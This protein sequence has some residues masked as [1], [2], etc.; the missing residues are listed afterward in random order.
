VILLFIC[1][2][3]ILKLL[4]LRG[5]FLRKLMKKLQ[6][7]IIS[8]LACV[9]MGYSQEQAC[10]AVLQN[11]EGETVEQGS[12]IGQGAVSGE[13]SKFDNW[14]YNGWGMHAGV[15]ATMFFGDVPMSEA[16]NI[17]AMINIGLQKELTPYLYW[18]IT[19]AYGRLAGNKDEYSNGS[20]ANLE[21]KTK[22]ADI[23]TTLKLDLFGFNE[24]LRAKKFAPYIYAGYGIVTFRSI[25]SDSQSGDR[26]MAYGY[27]GSKTVAPTH[28][29][30]IPLGLGL[31]WKATQALSFTLDGSMTVVHSDKV[32]ACVSNYNDKFL[33]DM[34]STV[35]LG[36]VYKFGTRDCD[37]DGVVNRNDK[38][39]DTPY[40]VAVNEDGCP[41]DSDGDG[42]PDYQDKCPKEAGLAQFEGC[43]DSDGDGIPDPDDECPQEAGLAQFNGCPDSDGDGI[44]DKDD[45]CPQEPGLAEFNGCPDSDGDGVPDKDDKCPDAA[46][47]AKYDGCPDSDGDGVPD[48]ID[49]CPQVAGLESNM[50][51]PAV[52]KEVM[53][54]FEKAL[55]GIQFE[56]GKDVI[57]KNSYPILNQVVTVMKENPEY[58]LEINGHTDNVGDPQKNQV[59]SEKRAAA[60]RKYLIDKGVSDTRMV[61]HGYGD[62]QPIADNKTS[63][64]RAKNRRVE[65]KV[66]FQ[67]LEEI[68]VVPEQTK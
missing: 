5:N 45:E 54:I 30:N 57:K 62:T 23:N 32:D 31:E 1:L 51:C 8:L 68:E 3:L 48:N 60:V 47:L 4:Y 44:P 35:S 67:K 34:F 58:N 12:W 38:C 59:L 50:G 15:G 16:S 56:T 9:S 14:F 22:Y 53:R 10:E 25:L 26:K 28:E 42:I 18:R 7:T 21:F 36:F 61:A 65:F 41:L 17:R 19:G 11:F 6:I 40:G 55:T 39:P 24:N 2:L 52:K 27:K 63:A 37:R 20:P 49:K 13:A 43:P 29:W 46:G 66:V 33:E 64:G